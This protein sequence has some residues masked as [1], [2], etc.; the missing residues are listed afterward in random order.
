[1]PEQPPAVLYT[2]DLQFV[3][4]AEAQHL[5]TKPRHG[6][7]LSGGGI[8]SASFAAGVMQALVLGN[9]LKSIDY[10]STVSGGGYIGSSLTWW[11]KQGL[12]NGEPAGTEPHN[13]PFGA[14]D[15]GPNTTAQNAILDYVRFHGNY[16]SPSRQLNAMSL[17]A[18]VIRIA[19]VSLTVYF[20]CITLVMFVVFGLVGTPFANPGDHD[21]QLFYRFA[22]IP[23]AILV[24]FFVLS[25]LYSIYTLVY[26]LLQ[27]SKPDRPWPS[28]RYKGRASWQGYFG[29]ILLSAVAFALLALLPAIDY[30]SATVERGRWLTAPAILIC[31]L[32]I[33]LWRGRTEPAETVVSTTGT[34]QLVGCSLILYSL[35]MSSFIASQYLHRM[36]YDIKFF[37]LLAGLV[38]VALVLGSLVNVNYLGIHRMYRDRLMELFLPNRESVTSNT[39]G[40][41]TNAD[42]MT[43][44]TMCQPPHMR[45]YHLVN[46]NVVLVDSLKNKY[47]GRGGDS[48]IISPLFCGS[49]ATG[50]CC[51]KAFMKKNDPG[52]TLA[53][54]MA[55]SGAAANPNTGVAGAGF[56]RN[57]LVATL[58]SLLNLRLGHWTPHPD[59][60]KSWR[61][62]PNF[63]F[64]GITSG[65]LVGRLSE[66]SRVVDLTDGGHFDNLGLYELIRR[67][68]P[69]IIVCD[70]SADP[71]AQC[72][73][74][75]TAIERIKI[76]FRTNVR[77]ENEEFDLSRLQPGSAE[78]VRPFD[79]RPLAKCGFAVGTITYEDHAKGTLLYIKATLT[80]G[81]PHD[82]YGYQNL[83]PAYPHETTTDQNFDETQFEAYREL[84]YHLAWQLLEAN[85][86][87]RV[88]P[89]GKWLSCPDLPLR[90]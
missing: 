66:N 88:H 35:V 53:T 67:R 52:M 41:A 45:P 80:P 21:R 60:K 24:L 77:F 17:A 47:K 57:R 70:G 69:V 74:L 22:T 28:R 19:T 75:A 18:G 51:S 3:L 54:A 81:L 42:G 90:P 2:K 37:C 26:Q 89:D 31:G 49:E 63:I 68:L 55:I 25:L 40:L 43:I 86:G 27:F 12:P 71:G 20:S 32:V 10:I 82:I 36:A 38:F 13:F 83:H 44:E 76:D 29:W 1:M 58:M 34:R 61:L 7:A 50:W 6:L 33:L 14:R 4:D 23:G 64:P 5:G 56:A 87:R 79:K 62:P 78:N 30:F 84:G 39:W 11:L 16:L 72:T 8:R 85:D 59:P 48:F 46:T 15:Q 65:V 73:D 9:V